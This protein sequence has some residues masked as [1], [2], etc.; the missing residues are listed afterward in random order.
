M[1]RT[2]PI[3]LSV[4]VSFKG[5]VAAEQLRSLAGYLSDAQKFLDKMDTSIQK[6]RSEFN[7]V[8]E[9]MNKVDELFE[10]HAEPRKEEKDKIVK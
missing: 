6:A 5:D 7:K 3:P 4:R 8:V 10:F 9:Q 1:P 2:K